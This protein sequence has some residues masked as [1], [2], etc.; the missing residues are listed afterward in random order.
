MTDHTDKLLETKNKGIEF[1]RNNAFDLI[2]VGIII[3]M[4]ALSLGAME[5][6][7]ITVMQLADI[8]LECIPFYLAATLLSANY[9]TKGTYAA[10]NKEVYTNSIK[11]Y[12]E[13]VSKLTGK[14]MNYLPDFCSQYNK[15]TLQDMQKELLNSVAITWQRYDEGTNEDKPLKVLSKSQLKELLGKECG[16]VVHKCKKMKI[17]GIYPNVLLSNLN[18][19]D[20]TNLGF[21][22]QQL[23]KKRLSSY[24][25]GYIGSIFF[26][27]LIGMKDVMQWGWMGIF[28]TLFKILYITCRAITKYYNG[29]EDISTHVV[30]Y[31]YR[32]S[33]IIKEFY[34][35]YD[36]LNKE[37]AVSEKSE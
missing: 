5:L 35:W 28:L 4:T 17:K 15:Q 33:D 16:K 11:Y 31:N 18:K 30:N 36:C 12:S 2:S 13:Q 14:H 26:M 10:K 24:A 7:D 19:E 25:I 3:A 29:Y 37:E 9:Y 6:R 1:V 8:I 20:R 23:A 21:T 32:K 22:E 27:S 34:Y